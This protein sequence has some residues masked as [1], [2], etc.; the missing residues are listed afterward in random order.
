[1]QLEASEKYHMEC[2]EYT[3]EMIPEDLCGAHVRNYSTI[4][5]LKRVIS[6]LRNYRSMALEVVEKGDAQS[7]SPHD[8]EMMGSGAE[9]SIFFI[10]SKEKLRGFD[11]CA[12]TSLLLSFLRGVLMYAKYGGESWFTYITSRGDVLQ[13]AESILKEMFDRIA[14][15][16]IGSDSTMDLVMSLSKEFRDLRIPN[17]H[18][19]GTRV[20]SM[21]VKEL[22]AGIRLMLEGVLFASR[23]SVSLVEE[24]MSSHA[25]DCE[26]ISPMK[27][28]V[29][30][31]QSLHDVINEIETSV[32]GKEESKTVSKL[33][34][35]FFY[36]S[37]ML[38]DA[39]YC[40]QE[41]SRLASEKEAGMSETKL[42][43][44]CRH[45]TPL[46]WSNGQMHHDVSF[47]FAQSV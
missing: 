46:K 32:V 19:V 40:L 1:V 22:V 21:L 39:R 37:G 17:V 47:L 36:V 31:A 5:F 44:V 38:L 30:R 3:K 29:E 11:V 14:Q 28:I 18:L 35:V 8:F 33:R 2:L 15:E 25:S 27:E 20:P 6:L 4:A 24:V 13:K 41:V 10:S 34:E 43:T 12:F 16:D 9:N 23:K 26:M 45:Y 42:I 7:L